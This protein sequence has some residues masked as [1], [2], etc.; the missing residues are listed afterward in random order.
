MSNFR[1]IFFIMRETD[2]G[3]TVREKTKQKEEKTKQTKTSSEPREQE[4]LRANDQ[5]KKK[6]LT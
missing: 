6:K 2:I 1:F 5:K 4:G 3:T